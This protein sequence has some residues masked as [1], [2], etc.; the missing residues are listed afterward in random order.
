[1]LLD[2]DRFFLIEG[3]APPSLVPGTHDPA[4]VGLSVLTAVLSAYIA[5]Q[6]AVKARESLT[7]LLRRAALTAGALSL[8]VGVWAMHFIGML[9]FQLCTQV[10]YD[11][12][13][14]ALSVLPALAAAAVALNQLAARRSSGWRL[15]AGGVLMGAGIGVMHYSGMAALQTPAS[16]RYDPLGFAASIVVA[17]VLAVLALWVRA[18]MAQRGW[19]D[20]LADLSAAVVMGS[21]IAGMHYTAMQASRFVGVADVSGMVSL[22]R[23]ADLALAIALVTLLVSALGGAV[24]SAL[25][26]RLLFQALR[27]SEARL[28]TLFDTA[29][30]SVLRMDAD[31]RVL[32][33]NRAATELFG[34]REAELIG[35]SLHELVPQLRTDQAKGA[36]RDGVTETVGRRLDGR[37]LPLR[38]AFGQTLSQGEAM[39]VA[40]IAD[41]SERRHIEQALQE[42][43]QQ[44]RS[45][46]ANLPGAA[47]HGIHDFATGQTELLYISD[48]I[49]RLT[50]W[51]PDE[52]RAPGAGLD[53]LLHPDDLQ[54]VGSP[55]R[56]GANTARTYQLE[57]RICRR[58]GE[59]RWF[60]ETGSITPL[61]GSRARID[62][63]LMDITE[64][65]LRNAEFSGVLT[66]IRRALVVIEFDLD[67]HILHVNDNFLALVGYTAE[68]LIGQHH[69]MLC[70]PEE[71][72]GRDYAEHWAALRRGEFRSGE[73]ERVGK[74]GRHIWIQATYNPILDA[75]GQPLRIVKFV[76]D[77]TERH[78]LVQD[79]R[80]AKDRAEQAAAAK[81]SFLANMSHEIRTPM[82]AII[83]FTDVVLDGELPPASRQHMQTVQRS[84]RA[85]LGLLNDILDTAKLENGAVELESRPFALR[86][87]CEDVLSTLEL[88]AR[89]KGLGLTLDLDPTLPPLVMGDPLRLRQVLLNLAGNAV[90]FTEQGAVTV[91]A[92]VRPDGWL[93][94][95]VADTGI[96]IAAD[97]L[98][99]IFDPFAQ[100]DASMT[101]RFGGTGL[102]TTIARQLVELMGGR[103]GVQ[104]ELGQGSRFWV[105]VPLQAADASAAASHALNSHGPSLPPL[106]IL[107]AD[108]VP[109]NLTLLE[110]RLRQ[111]GHTVTT[112]THGGE[113]L[114]AMRQGGFDLA[115]LDVQMPVMDGLQACREL[116]QFEAA[117]GAGHLPVIAL[118]AS[119]MQGDRDMTL[120]A[121]MDGFAVKPIDWPVLLAEIARVLGLAPG[122]ELTPG[123][124]AAAS[125]ATAAT[126][127][128]LPPGIDW[129][130]GLARWGSAEL[131]RGQLLRFLNDSLDRWPTGQEDAAWAHRLRGTLANLG[132][133]D[134]GQAL[135]ALEHGTVAD[136]PAA[137]AAQQHRLQA[138]RV[139]LQDAGTPTVP[140]TPDA[141]TIEHMPA[142]EPADVRALDAALAKGEMPDALC[143]R[144][145][146]RLPVATRERLDAAMM[147]FEFDEARRVLA[148]LLKDSA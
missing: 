54:R 57:F 121:G 40:F 61:D 37:E 107:I 53:A 110:L 28:Q 62:S 44:H 12:R 89:R 92:T 32:G 10:G 120:A 131:L 144:V 22:S 24:S 82:N 80:I 87:L 101:R 119:V 39:Q 42:S 47:V 79:L 97:R 50:G 36:E 23:H 1:M 86:Q 84:A 6:L 75:N 113:A 73:Y 7:P 43:E 109:E 21:A 128:G 77:L 3:A 125:P 116:R 35:R 99:R 71:A 118:T 72:V 81:S 30:D 33:V 59:V 111:Q 45:L 117:Q 25:R 27:R 65:Q 140:S 115:L 94:L 95:S 67:G 56:R 122:S 5:L 103:I 127:A 130:A 147:D 66:A 91:A 8:G 55:A 51:T 145:L 138:L 78:A 135:D 106:R 90:K 108:D 4:L 19:P 15:L 126:V 146:S 114:E 100:A 141:A 60:S 112:A 68:E 64:Q 17:V 74:D 129:S 136:A 105:R 31:G 132:V 139:Q 133:P 20:R 58:D 34:G 69:R 46:I 148:G 96:G 102:G 11:H 88:N 14:T 142:P 13:I 143:Q 48:R 2:L 85:L 83:G 29:V 134:D 104:S 93:E 16:L 137:W 26:H 49:E 123:A 52:L 38:V 63:L 41:I 98:D 76:T 124:A 70:L 18:A 9:A